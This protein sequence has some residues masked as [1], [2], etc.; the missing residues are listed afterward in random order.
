MFHAE[1]LGF[2][3]T[4]VEEFQ[5]LSRD[6][7]Q[8]SWSRTGNC[9]MVKLSDIMIACIHAPSAMCPGVVTVLHPICLRGPW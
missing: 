5:L 9:T 3:H 1:S 2:L 6:D 7:F 4:A 8:S